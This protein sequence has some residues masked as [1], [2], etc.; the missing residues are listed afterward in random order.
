MIKI[1]EN[2]QSENYKLLKN[3]ILDNTF[4]WYY[5][6]YSVI[7][8]WEDNKNPLK[9]NLENYAQVPFY[10]HTILD[11]PEN[12]KYSSASSNFLEDSIVAINEIIK[13]NFGDKRYFH[14]RI[15]A[16]CTHPST[17]IQFS[18]PHQDHEFDHLN[19]ICYLNN[20]GGRTFIDGHQPYEPVEDECIV[21]SG[22]HYG[23]LPKKKR[24]I[25]LVSTIFPC[26]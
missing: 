20:A 3:N 23:E 8:S 15:S 17:G 24:R 10:S 16:N 2:P 9:D 5:S 21:F 13:Y 19:F 4:P 18:M 22:K 6:N 26:S 14:L 7:K 11:R 1:L 25:V 12:K